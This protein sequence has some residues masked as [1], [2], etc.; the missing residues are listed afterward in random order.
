MVLELYFFTSGASCGF[1]SLCEAVPAVFILLRAL[2][3]ADLNFAHRTG[4]TSYTEGP[5]C[6]SDELEQSMPTN[7]SDAKLTRSQTLP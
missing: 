4:E 6:E 5:L 2:S 7:Y 3:S 1:A